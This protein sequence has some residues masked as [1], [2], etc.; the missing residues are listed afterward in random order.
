MYVTNRKW[1]KRGKR[2]VSCSSVM[3]SSIIKP[4]HA[5]DGL[6]KRKRRKQSIL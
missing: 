3:T 2:E 1:G 5:A 4:R 6:G